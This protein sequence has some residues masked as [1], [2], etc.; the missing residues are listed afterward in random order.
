M[1]YL[2]FRSNR[3]ERSRKN[4]N[5]LIVMQGHAVVQVERIVEQ[6]GASEIV[7]A[8]GDTG[9]SPGRLG[10]ALELSRW[11]RGRQERVRQLPGLGPPIGSLPG[12]PG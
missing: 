2:L 8:H 9:M 1:S 7:E 3:Y 5:W 12:A 4:N 11:A 6:H 10:S